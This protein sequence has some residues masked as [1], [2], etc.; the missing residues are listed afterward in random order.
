VPTVD[1]N[2]RLRFWSWY[3]MGGSDY[4]VVEIRA[5]TNVNWTEVSPRYAGNSGVWTRPS[6]DLSAYAG[7]TVQLAFYIVD[8]GQSFDYQNPGWY[9]DE[10]TVVTGPITTLTAN[11]PESFENGL[12]DWYAESGTWEV[13]V[14]TSGPGAAHAG[15][16]CA[17]TVLSGNYPAGVNSRLVSPS[18][19]VPTADQNPRLRF[20][21]WYS[22]GGSDYAVAEIRVGTNV[23]WTE[24]SPRYAG[25]SGVWTRPSIDLSA[26]AGKTVQLA[27]Y[28]VDVGQ[29]FDYQNPGWYV[30]EV[31]LRSG[32]DVFNNPETFEFGWGDWS[33]DNYGLWQ[34]GVPT[35]G[36][37]L[38]TNTGSRAHS[39]VSVAATILNGNY[40]ANVSSRLISP[41][42]TVPSVSPGSVL[43]L[44]FWQYYQYGTGDAGLV[45]IASVSSPTNW[46]TLTVA[47]TNG[48]CTNWTLETVDLSAYQ[49]QQVRLGFYHTAN[50]D[51]SVGAGWYLDDMSAS[52]FVPT[53]LTLGLPLTNSFTANGQYQY[54]AV[55]V[56]PGGHL[57]VNLNALA[58]NG[59]N[60]VYLS[61]GVLPSPGSYDYRF[62]A[63][64]TA[65]QTIFAPNAGA[66]TWY[67]LAYNAAGAVPKPT[68][69]PPNS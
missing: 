52:S 44:R 43:T 63:N 3:L 4:G 58:V 30:D 49:G 34:I 47:A 37:P 11:V 56:P 24:V 19:A 68:R 15:T 32:P 6:I 35:Y 48:T 66:G 54:F 67:V 13:G 10:V 17:A 25:N 50:S 39:P 65:N 23:S 46:T 1:Q 31:T 59:A 9:V 55:Q 62:I 29:S 40:P 41:S 42:F 28:I 7:K 64:G 38:N 12:G 18:F 26:Y 22:M 27:F 33:T 69:S 51:A 16:N 8:V 20:W 5:G 14:P 60:E 57:Q 21:S 61:R 2:P 36:S 45:Q 53:P